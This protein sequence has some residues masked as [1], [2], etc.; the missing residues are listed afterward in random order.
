[1]RAEPMEGKTLSPAGWGVIA[2]LVGLWEFPFTGGM[3]T[4]ILLWLQTPGWVRAWCLSPRLSQLN[5]QTSV[6]QW[7]E[8]RTGPSCV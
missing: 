1:M 2:A 6:R 8:T 7:L 5:I 3:E 4:D